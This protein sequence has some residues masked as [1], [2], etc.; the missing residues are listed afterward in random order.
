M[1][2]LVRL[3]S[4]FEISKGHQLALSHLQECTS[5]KG[6]AYVARSHRNNGVTA[7]VGPIQG[8]KPADAG[9]ISVC[10]RSRNHSLSAFVQPRPYYTAYHVAVLTPK[11]EMTLKEKL[12]WCSCIQSNRFRFNYGR[13]A[14]R[15]VESLLVPKDVP[16]WVGDVEVGEFGGGP[17]GE[18]TIGSIE[19]TAWQ[20]FRLVDLFDIHT[21]SYVKRR[22]LPPGKVPFVSAS[23]AKNGVS[24]MVDV[25]PEWT[26]GQ[27]TLANNGSI[28]AAFYQRRPFVAS[29]DV[30]VLVPK[31][32]MS[33]A[34]AL[35]VCTVLRIESFRF[36]YARKWTVGRMRESKIRLP[37]INGSPDLDAMEAIVRGTKVGWAIPGG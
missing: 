2:E 4:L 20:T 13:Q 11:Q 34:A 16:A 32:E 8:T 37:A 24:A 36:N 9:T 7:W 26:G 22:D 12:W 15:T 10:L 17:Q 30:S 35:F 18:G 27:I 31:S 23:D 21:G 33:D 25:A 5:G 14:N 28:G 1:S 6:I 3:D 29:R 19:T